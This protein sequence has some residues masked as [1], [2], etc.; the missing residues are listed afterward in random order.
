MELFRILALC[1]ITAVL[2]VIFRQY[3][4]EYAL[5]L[6]VAAAIIILSVIFKRLMPKIEEIKLLI[7]TAGIQNEYLTVALKAL[8]IA[9]LTE[10]TANTCRDFG[11]SSLASK[12][13]LAGKVSIFIISIPLMTSVLKT[14][15]NLL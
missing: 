2:A 14:A 9:Y 10:F 4:Q 6:S 8:L 11:Q 13:E 5:F 3:R 1:L 15:L 7:S 12:A